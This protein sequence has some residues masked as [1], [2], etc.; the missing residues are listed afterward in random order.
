MS[1]SG[2]WGKIMGD[3]V[4]SPQ[5]TRAPPSG[6]PRSFEEARPPPPTHTPQDE[7]RGDTAGTLSEA[8]SQG[9]A[10]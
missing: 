4:R 1:D 7:I 3:P 8:W 10:R 5:L 9:R 2:H 6:E